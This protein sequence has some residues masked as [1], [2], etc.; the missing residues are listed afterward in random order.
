M[1]KCQNWLER[2]A[3]TDP[4]E[5]TFLRSEMQAWLIVVTKAA[6]QKQSEEQK[7]LQYDD[8]DNWYGKD[9]ILR[10][11]HTTLDEM[12][13]RCAYMDRHNLSNERIVLD[14]AKSVKKREMTVWQNM[15]NVLNDELFAPLTMS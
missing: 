14:N 5:V 1:L 12:E 10:L 6:E 8:G 13:I 2:Y 15:A 4:S 7:L 9:H 11:I 3:I